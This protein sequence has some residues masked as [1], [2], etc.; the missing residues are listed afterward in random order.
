MEG[1]DIVLIVNLF[2]VPAFKQRFGN[3]LPDGT[4]DLSAA[5]QSGLSNGALVGEILGLMINGWIADRIGYRKTMIGALILVTGFI[6][7]V[8][9]VQSLVQLLIG[10]I[11]MGI[12]WYGLMRLQTSGLCIY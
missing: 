12:P 3:L 5:W 10:L 2:A 6:F 4:Y 1:F 9:F 7:I 11:L 8:F